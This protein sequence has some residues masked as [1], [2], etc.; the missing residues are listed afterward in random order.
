M[1]KKKPL[2]GVTLIWPSNP[3]Q[4]L[5]NSLSESPLADRVCLLMDSWGVGPCCSMWS[6]DK[7]AP[8]EATKEVESAADEEFWPELAPP[9]P[10]LGG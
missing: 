2:I 1:F 4:C 10:P 6:R 7:V 5:V 9:P 3:L 8:P